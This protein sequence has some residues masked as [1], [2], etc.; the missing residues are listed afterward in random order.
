MN[1]SALNS[2]T[3]V[4]H[5]FAN[6]SFAIVSASRGLY[7]QDENQKRTDQL[8]NEI[9]SL[10]YGFVKMKGSY[11]EGMGTSEQKEVHEDV[12]FI[13]SKAMKEDEVPNHEEFNKQNNA[14]FKKDMESLGNKFDQEAIIFK[15]YGE[16]KA[17]ILGTTDVN[18]N[19]EPV[20]PG[21]GVMS[22]AGDTGDLKA[23]KSGTFHTMLW[24][25][26]RKFVFE[27]VEL[28]K[29]FFGSWSDFLHKKMIS[30]SK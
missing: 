22:I 6:N 11:I 29:S 9:R 14:N 30:E 21:K 26:K 25:N 8:R 10:G 16:S 5:H 13:A 3:R 20:W 1:E 24:K 27:S 4:M 12:F 2:L 15:P 28:P 7:G 18:E 17:Y 23:G 19:G